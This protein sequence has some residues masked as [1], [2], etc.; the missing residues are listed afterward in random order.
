MMRIE[1]L[2]DHE[3]LIAELARLIIQEWFFLRPMIT[4]EVQIDILRKHCG[5]QQIPTILVATSQ[6]E[7]LGSAALASQG[8][9]KMQNLCPWVDGV[10]VNP[11]YRKQGIATRLIGRI[12]KVASSLGVKRL[13]LSTAN[14]EAFYSRLGWQFIERCA[15]KGIMVSVMQ[16]T[17][18]AQPDA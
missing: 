10:F 16:K 14:A 17:V 18:I 9:D 11:A 3:E 5:H 7:I 1:Y 2:I 15:Y 13:Y 4:L 12:E 8:P 6:K